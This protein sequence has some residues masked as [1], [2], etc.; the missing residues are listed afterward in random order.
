MAAKANPKPKPKFKQPG[1]VNIRDIVI[2]P[3]LALLVI[4]YLVISLSTRNWTWFLPNEFNTRPDH[5]EIYHEGEQ[6]VLE[7]GDPGY[8]E[9][10]GELNEQ[11]RSIQGY[12]EVGINETTLQ[13]SQERSTVVIMFYDEPLRMNSR[14]N[15]GEPDRILIPITGANSNANRVYTGTE[16]GFGHGGL[17]LQDLS[18]FISIVK[19]LGFQE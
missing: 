7:P 15:L 6:V 19:G 10:T 4:G 9:L 18:E 17:V 14:W 2:V 1:E 8:D 13:E 5:I 11:L 12:Y 16:N 3:L